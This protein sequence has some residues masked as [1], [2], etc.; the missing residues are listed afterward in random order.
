MLG[1]SF[2]GGTD[3]EVHESCGQVMNSPTMLS[4]T[5]L[6][7]NHYQQQIGLRAEFSMFSSGMRT[8]RTFSA[9]ILRNLP[10]LAFLPTPPRPFL[11]NHVHSCVAMASTSPYVVEKSVTIAQLKADEAFVALTQQEASYALALSNAEWLVQPLN[12]L[13]CAIWRARQ[14]NQTIDRSSSCL[15]AGPEPRFV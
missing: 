8:A 4:S 6:R 12:A 3:C 15:C 11:R 7:G 10:P 5:Y 2:A 9:R 13:A 1:C 14:H